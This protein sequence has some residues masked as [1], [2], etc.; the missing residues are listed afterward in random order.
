[1]FE[2]MLLPSGH[3]HQGRFAAYAFAGELLA[4]TALM[5]A[6]IE[7]PA[8]K[9]PDATVALYLSA[10]APPPPAPA[11][12]APA[13]TAV[14]KFAP[15]IFT[16]P[17]FTAPQTIP[18]H[19][20]MITDA[21]PALQDVTGA[22]LGGV[23]GGVPGGSLNGL[24]GTLPLPAPVATRTPPK[25]AAAP[26]VPEAPTQ[27]R[28]GGEVEASRLTHEVVPVYPPIAKR[29]LIQGTVRMSA[30]I[31][32]DGTVKDLRVISGNP[33]LI[34]AAQKA[35]KQWIYHPTYLNGNP[36]EVL[37]EINVNFTLAFDRG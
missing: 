14:N 28:V 36:V 27:I 32:A 20:A 1:M 12:R 23:P 6:Y 5:M 8:M 30:I 2:Q 26:P 31:A 13:R 29:A 10:P 24:L 11:V 35:V 3:T 19:A 25:P 18:Q 9:L 15:R 37:T 34:E 4:V 7:G 22:V 17:M 16:A 33:L 21:E